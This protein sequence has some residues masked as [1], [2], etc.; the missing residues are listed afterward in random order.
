MADFRKIAAFVVAVT[1]PLGAA[2]VA[3]A[4][5][6]AAEGRE[7][8]EV[9]I[10]RFL[11][12]QRLP[13]KPEIRGTVMG[14]FS[15]FDRDPVTGTWYFISDDR[16]RYNPAR[17]YTGQLD[18]DRVSGAFRGVRVTGVT[19]F[20]QADGRPYPAYGRPGSADPET[21]RFDPRTGRLLWAHEGDRPDAAHRDIPL[22]QLF[23][24]WT[25]RRGRHLGGL[26]I[27]RNLIMTETERGPR[28]N[29]GFE[30]LTLA[31]NSIAAVAEG[32]RY[33]DGRPPS[34]YRGAP[35]RITV[36]DR[37][38]RLRAQYAYPLDRLPA[39]PSPETGGADSGVSEILALDDHRYLAL[40]RSWVEGSGY[41]TKLYEIDLRGATNVLA[42]N[43]LA[44]GRP[45]R[46]VRK[47]LVLDLTRFGHPA[48]NLEGLAWGPRLA[49]GECTLVTG[50]DDN[51][52]SREVTQFLAFATRAC[53]RP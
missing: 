43:S 46:P 17:F 44:D 16:W 41:F 8:G 28:R 49:S 7:T 52:D 50:S 31:P 9:R 35:A 51:F 20:K 18:I 14:G 4:N 13:H 6:Q 5:A 48:Q 36:W 27:P 1:A 23:V 2:P 39:E 12:E 32:P 15:G 30:G 38:G 33:E 53:P 29:Y 11:G 3:S 24:R 47:R 19:T 10:T 40:E 37:G 42:R 26:P 45:Y 34:V 22:S 25:D 21:I